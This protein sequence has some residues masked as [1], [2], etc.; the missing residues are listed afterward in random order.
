[1]AWSLHKARATI[2]VRL[3]RCISFFYRASL[4]DR[5]ALKRRYQLARANSEIAGLVRMAGQNLS[6]VSAIS[7]I[8]PIQKT[9]QILAQKHWARVQVAMSL[10]A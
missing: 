7:A 6:H 3:Y 2:A 9:R 10:V 1:V 4:V 8:L 5:E